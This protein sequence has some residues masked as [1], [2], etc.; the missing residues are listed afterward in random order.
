M[1]LGPHWAIFSLGAWLTLLTWKTYPPVP[2]WPQSPIWKQ[3]TSTGWIT[4]QQQNRKWCHIVHDFLSESGLPWS[5]ASRGALMALPVLWY[6]NLVNLELLGPPSVLN[7][8]TVYSYLSSSVHWTHS[9]SPHRSWSWPLTPGKPGGPWTE[10]PW[11][12][13]SPFRPTA[14]GSPGGPVRP[15]TNRDGRS[16]GEDTLRAACLLC[17]H[18]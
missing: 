14:P 11:S 7:Q 9:F 18:L 8:T 15:E 12:P 13:L 17:D 6:Q 16:T 4:K 2:L 5:P 1:S 3:E 10:K